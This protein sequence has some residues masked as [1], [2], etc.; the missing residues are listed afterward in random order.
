MFLNFI[1]AEQDQTRQ[2]CWRWQAG[3]N[4]GRLFRRRSGKYGQHGRHPSSCW[5][6]VEKTGVFKLCYGRSLSRCLFH[7]HYTCYIYTRRSQ[8]FTKYIQIVFELLGSF[9]VIAVH[10]MLA[11]STAVAANCFKIILLM[12]RKNVGKQYHRIIIAYWFTV[13]LIHL[14]K[15]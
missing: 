5:R 4:D 3:Q 2:L 10:K 14:Q 8:K 9:R 15:C 1:P 6:W 13:I 11:K 7:Q 12:H